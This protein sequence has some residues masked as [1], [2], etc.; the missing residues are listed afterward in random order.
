MDPQPESSLLV[1]EPGPLLGCGTSTL[2]GVCDHGLRILCLKHSW[3]LGLPAAG[4]ASLVPAD[5]VQTLSAKLPFEVL[6]KRA[7]FCRKPRKLQKSPWT[8]HFGGA[9]G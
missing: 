8:F 2:T 7:L 3:A 1:L 6:V 9:A 4:S 5:S